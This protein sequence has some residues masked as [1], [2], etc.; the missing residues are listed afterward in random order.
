MLYESFNLRKEDYGED[1]FTS[2]FDGE[3]VRGK[4]GGNG[5]S[6]LFQIIVW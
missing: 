6:H 5:V 1:F 4:R 2:R 3:I